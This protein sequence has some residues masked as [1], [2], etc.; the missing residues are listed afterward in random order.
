VPA[1]DCW[2]DA[3]A[4]A[5]DLNG[6]LLEG[7]RVNGPFRGIRDFVAFT[8]KRIIAVNVHG[9]TDKKRDSTSL[10]RPPSSPPV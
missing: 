2:H 4:T 5:K 10:L 3:D 9:I 1:G 8:E 7:E 6:L